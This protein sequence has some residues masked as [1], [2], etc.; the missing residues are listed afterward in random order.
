MSSTHEVLNQAPPLT[1]FTTAD[2]PALLEALRRDGGGRGEE[3]VRALG[4]RAGSEEVQEWARQAEAYPPVL[5]THDRYGHRVDEVEFHPAWHHLMAAAVESGQHAAPWADG[6]PG[7]HLIRAA[8]F[9]VW[10]QAEPGHGCPISMTNAAVPAL[11]AQPDLAAVYEPLLASP[12]YDYGLRP[13]LGKRGLI[14]GMSMTE[15]QGGSDVRANTT[16]AVPAGDGTYVITGH[17]WF[18]S[19]PMSDVFLVLAQAEQGLTCFLMPRVLPDGTRNAMRLQ[20][21]KDKLGNRSNASSEIEYEQAVAWPVGEPGR[22]VRTIVE[23][24]NMT[25]LDCVI[26]SAAGMRAGLR[27]ALHHTTYRRAFGAE[28]IGQPLMRNVLADLAVESEAATALAMRLATA[29]DRSEAGDEAERALRRLALAAGKYWVCKRGSAHAAEALE[30]LGGNGYV[31]E[32]GMPRLYREAPLLSI[33]EGSGNVA[34]LDVLRALTREPQALDAY[35]AEIDA[36]A[37][38]DSRLD[39]AT[40]RLRTLLTTLD[41]PHRAQLTARRL[42]E[43]LTLVLQGSL[44]VR[45]ST[46]AMADAFCASRLAGDWG[47]AFGTLPP[48]ADLGGVLERAVVKDAG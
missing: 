24:V 42:A 26:G 35:F 23:M 41:D 17:K 8:K 9:Y 25:R 11:R 14:A 5:R 3:E 37:G 12:V 31:E 16:T 15:K 34:A 30:C 48:G 19:A 43:H 39:A 13:P 38:A 6:R 32:S 47:G 2:D 33:W 20:R 46:P 21:L 10:A 36:A 40:A 18:T 44:L 28:L 22:G 4:V 7:A 45:H 1:G 29:L 27:Q